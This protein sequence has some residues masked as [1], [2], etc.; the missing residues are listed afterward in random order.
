M[1]D[2]V[3]TALNVL[4]EGDQDFNAE[5]DEKQFKGKKYKNLNW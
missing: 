1:L 3:M 5:I 4:A 2:E